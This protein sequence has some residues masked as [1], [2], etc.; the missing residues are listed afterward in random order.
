MT[1]HFADHPHDNFFQHIFKQPEEAA[2]FLRAYLPARLRKIADWST[3]EILP[4]AY[5]SQRLGKSHGDLLYRLRVADIETWI[6]I[7]VEHQSDISKVPMPYRCYGYIKQGW[8]APPNHAPAPE[9]K[10]KSRRKKP[11]PTFPLPPVL[12][13][14]VHQGP[15]RYSGPTSFRQLIA[16]T[17]DPEADALLARFTP[18]FDILEALKLRF[19]R[20]PAGLREA[21]QS[22]PCR[23]VNKI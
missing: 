21:V 6:H 3:L 4:S 18:Q 16:S 10:P 7:I 17:G 11:S 15:A 20:V 5:V 22:Q 13:F 19:K 23:K 12:T 1:T 14:L 2:G 9:K 8:D